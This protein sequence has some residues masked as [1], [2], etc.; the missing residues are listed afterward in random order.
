M[1]PQ[2]VPQCW[3]TV[4][5]CLISVALII[6]SCV[7][8]LQDLPWGLSVR[9]PASLACPGR[10]QAHWHF[11]WQSGS[12]PSP[13]FMVLK[14]STPSKLHSLSWTHLR[15]WQKLRPLAPTKDRCVSLSHAVEG[16]RDLRVAKKEPDI[17]YIHTPS[18]F[19]LT[20]KKNPSIWY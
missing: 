14:Y 1:T 10:W 9:R 18:L 6:P 5:I 11:P 12:R 17:R 13:C 19:S 16:G 2:R 8:P 7:Q 3:V 15:I 20:L 4:I